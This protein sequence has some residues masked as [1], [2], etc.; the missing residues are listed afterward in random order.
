M[1]EQH[2]G[3][4][5]RP[6]R[7]KATGTDVFVGPHIAASMSGLKKALAKQDAVVAVSGPVGCGKT[8]LVNRVLESIGEHCKVVNVARMRVDSED[9]LELL[10]N[11]LGLADIPCG[12]IQRF[13]LF[14][15]EL[16]ALEDAGKRL[17]VTIE[18]GI[19]L[20]AD[21]LAEVEALTAADTGDSEGA[22]IVLMADE[23]S[24]EL[25]GDR[26][27]GRLQQR[28][29]QR[30]TIAPLL[31][32]ELRGYLRHCFRLIGGEFE[33]I[34]EA[35]AVELLHFLGNG[36]L[37]ITNN[38]VESA[39]TAAAD[40][41]LGKVPSS[42]LARIAGT[43]SVRPALICPRRRNRRPRS[44]KRL[45]KL[46]RSRRSPRRNPNANLKQNRPRPNRK[47]KSR[48]MKATFPS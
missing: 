14:R 17:F 11:E 45:R 23:R 35:N 1:Y 42:L 31:V 3:L 44:R 39:M 29:R 20:G 2:F 22:C 47:P 5:K 38:L 41:D 8:T 28:M 46:R 37:R 25:L 18:D 32:A 34:F 6:F 16:K 27:L 9:V 24:D 13:A 10:L 12:T 40:Q 21:T 33:Q 19:R 7:A 43:A 48:A 30:F 26:Q 36:V 15:H 4:R